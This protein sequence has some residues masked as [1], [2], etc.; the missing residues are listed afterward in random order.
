[1][2]FAE[3]FAINAARAER[4]GWADPIDDHYHAACVSWSAIHAL[5]PVTEQFHRAWETYH[6]SLARLL[7]TARDEG[8]FVP[9]QGLIINDPSGPSLVPLAFRGCVWRRDDIQAIHPVGEYRTKLLSRKYRTEG[10]GVPVVVERRIPTGR[11]AEESFLTPGTMFAATALLRHDPSGTILELVDSL[12]PS[13]T[14]TP[15]VRALASDLSAPF[16]LRVIS[17][18]ELESDWQSFFGVDF[19]TR[20]GLFFLEPYQAGKIP[21][22][23][24]HGLLSNPAAWIDLANDLRAAPGFAE[25]F[26]LWG[27]RYATGGPFLESASLL[28]KDLSRAVATVDAHQTDPALSRIVLV[29]HSMGGLLCELQASHSK[30]RLW[31]TISHRPLSSIVATPESRQALQDMFFFDPQPNVRCVISLGAPHQGSNWANRPVGRLGALLARPEP[32]RLARHRQLIHDNPDTFSDEVAERVPTSVDMLNPESAVL[33]AIAT[34]PTSP[35][36]RFHTVFGY[37]RTS[38]AEGPGDGIVS[39][40]SAL[41]PRSSSQTGIDAS[42]MTIHRKLESAAEILRILRNEWA[43]YAGTRLTFGGPLHGANHG[44][45]D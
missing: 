8:R 43:E 39:M 2:H 28:R 31:N 34:L 6:L 3:D 36:V 30:D 7:A 12:H 41:S 13:P 19:P 11:Y 45:Q 25:H 20:Q 16:A 33:K 32:S 40:D 10:W 23:L 38:L 27:F 21:V 26:Q 17:S 24:V 35:C 22:V 37:G 4:T 14:S 9:G 5:D 29:G 42:H 1:L 18:P 44:R 15:G